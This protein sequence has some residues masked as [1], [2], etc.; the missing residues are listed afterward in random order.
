M[1]L[2]AIAIAL[3]LIAPPG[4]VPL[5]P[6][7]PKPAGLA[8]LGASATA[9][10]GVIVPV[11]HPSEGNRYRHVD[12]NDALHAVAPDLPEAVTSSGDAFFFRR[13]LK[14]R[15]L[16]VDTVIASRPEAVIALDFLFW[17]GHGSQWP[18]DSQTKGELRMARMNKGL[19]QLDKIVATGI[20]V[21]VGNLPDV[22]DAL[23]ARFSV[24]A[25]GQVPKAEVREAMNA[26]IHEW[27]AASEN[28]HLIPLYTL[29]AKMSQGKP[30]DA[31]GTTWGPEPRLMLH[32][33]L[34]PSAEGLLAIAAVIADTLHQARAV[35]VTPIDRAQA[36]TRLQGE[37]TPTE[38]AP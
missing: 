10:W 5:T 18:R 20:P 35:E 26:R 15:A 23:N 6:H 17:Y 16:Q 8:L 22:S 27:A 9:G 33:Q 11:E 4:D 25:P 34:H 37:P 31:G 7:E 38:A 32:D 29:M 24:L 12:L 14:A 19:A 3:V 36:R 30:I 28:V 21:I 2:I 1:Q 13:S